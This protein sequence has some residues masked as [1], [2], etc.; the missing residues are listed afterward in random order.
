MMTAGGTTSGF[1]I[2]GGVSGRAA[3]KLGRG[4]GGGVHF[5]ELADRDVGVDLRC[6]QIRVA[7]D[8]LDVTDVGAELE[9]QRR[10]LVAEELRRVAGILRSPIVS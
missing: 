4:V 7:E 3:A 2:A 8:C 1:F 10:H 6:L 9:H 5:F